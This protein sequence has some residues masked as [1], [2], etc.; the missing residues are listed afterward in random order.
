MAQSDPAE[1]I[2]PGQVGAPQPVLPVLSYEK[3]LVYRYRSDLPPPGLAAKAFWKA[4]FV[5]G[6]L[7]G[8]VYRPRPAPRLYRR[9]P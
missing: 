1:P 3:P 9:D 6:K 2:V 8:M 5:A 4:C 7:L